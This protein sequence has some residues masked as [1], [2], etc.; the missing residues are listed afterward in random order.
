MHSLFSAPRLAVVL[1]VPAL[2]ALLALPARGDE[3]LHPIADQVKASLKDPAKPFTLVVSLK[4]KEDMGA[5]FEATFAK[6]VGPTR[7]EKG[8]LAYEL[9]R[10]PKGGGQYL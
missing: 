3:K 1:A 9:N 7:K 8:C 2:A 4:V 10:D 6:A 5:K